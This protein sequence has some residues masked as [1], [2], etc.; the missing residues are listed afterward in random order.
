MRYF[1]HTEPEIKEMLETVG[2]KSVSGLFSSI[3]NSCRFHEELKLP[4]PMSETELLGHLEQLGKK[5]KTDAVSFLGAGAYRHFVPS[6]VTSVVSRSEFVTPYTPYQPEISQGTLMA[7]FEYQSMIAKIFQMD[8]VNASHYDGATATAEASLLSMRFTKREKILVADSVH[9]EYLATVETILKPSDAE[10]VKIP[11][12]ENGT[13][14]RKQLAAACDSN[15]S[16]LVAGY[17]NFFGVLDEL[18]DLGDLIHKHGGLFVVSV[19]EPLSMGIIEP[20]GYLGADIV[21]AEG[22]SFGCGLNYGGPY[23]GIFAAKAKFIRVMPGRIVGETA[24]ADGKRG[25]VLTLST[26]EQHIRREKAT[27]NICS[28]EALCATTAAVYLSLLGKEGFAKLAELNFAK[29]EYAK[30]QFQ[31]SNFKLRF[32]GPTFN[33]FV[34]DLGRPADD[35]AADLAKEGIFAGLPLGRFYP[36]LA[37]CLL[38]CTTELNSKDEIDRLVKT[39]CS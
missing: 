36:E 1:P 27:S 16:C 25:Y 11:S 19:P 35:A 34:V 20:P 31:N 30:K 23:L 37:N 8:V 3:P 6:A 21:C 28:N 29:S 5:N 9:P 14:D 22:Q 2:S 15:C 4:P 24:D 18:K 17:P 32:N 38:V 10:I 33:E 12:T 7:I 39:L 26:R 13:I